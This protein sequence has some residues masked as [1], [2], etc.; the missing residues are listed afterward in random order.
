LALTHLLSNYLPV[1]TTKGAII[2][3]R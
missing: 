2:M 1:S 3:L